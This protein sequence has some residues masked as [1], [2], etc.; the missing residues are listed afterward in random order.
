MGRKCERMRYISLFLIIV[1][2]STVNADISLYLNDSP[3]PGSI[4]ILLDEILTIPVYSNDSSMWLGYIIQ[5]GVGDLYNP[6]PPAD[7][8]ELPGWGNG[9]E[10]FGTGQAGIQYLL[11]YSSSEAGTAFVTLWLDPDYETQ[12][13]IL[14][15]AVVPEPATI[16]LLAFG[17]LAILKKH[18]V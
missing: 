18:R 10:L 2:A 15:I 16:V 5:D 3:A 4:E 6:R 11:D 17:G 7:P 12:A 13:D 14:N 8:F 1:L 9:Y